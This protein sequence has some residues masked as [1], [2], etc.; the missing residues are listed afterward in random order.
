[1]SRFRELVGDGAHDGCDF[2]VQTREATVAF[3][4]RPIEREV[5]PRPCWW[6]ACEECARLIART[7]REGLAL[8]VWDVQF[9]AMPW[10]MA[11]LDERTHLECV[12]AKCDLFWAARDGAPE[13]L[14]REAMP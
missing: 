2:C 10:A 14:A 11:C 13:R 12:R 6:L 5:T 1:V 8:R 7:D 4:T 3:P 9:D